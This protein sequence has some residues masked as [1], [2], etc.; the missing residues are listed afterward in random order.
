MKN[1]DWMM[2]LKT[3]NFLQKDQE[4]KKNDDEIPTTIK[5]K[6][7]FSEKKWKNKKMKV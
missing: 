2:K 5:V 6:L 7:W 1:Y 3:N 4:Q